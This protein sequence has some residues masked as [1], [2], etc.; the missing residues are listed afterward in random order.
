MFIGEYL[1]EGHR[2]LLLRGVSDFCRKPVCVTI[3]L[4]LAARYGTL[5]CSACSLK[6]GDE[7]ALI[8]IRKIAVSSKL[9]AYR[10][11]VRLEQLGLHLSQAICRWLQAYNL[12]LFSLNPRGKDGKEDETNVTREEAPSTR[13]Q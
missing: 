4:I 1:H 3:H 5:W 9:G 7:R 13:A 6:T 12:R 11:R 2:A 8:F 10:V